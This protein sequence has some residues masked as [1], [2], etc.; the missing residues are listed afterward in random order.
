MNITCT[1]NC[2]SYKEYNLILRFDMFIHVLLKHESPIFI[3]IFG[4]KHKI[5]HEVIKDLINC[6][7]YCFSLSFVILNMD[8]CILNSL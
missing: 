4:C 5:L 7:D 6:C 1:S 3:P 2:N 8:N